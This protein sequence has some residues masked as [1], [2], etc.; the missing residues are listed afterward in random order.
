M[1]V[2]LDEIARISGVSKTTVSYVLSGKQ[3]SMGISE[4]TIR[5][6]RAVADELDYAKAPEAVAL[7]K[8]RQK[9]KRV[10]ILSPWFTNPG[11][12]FVTE[13][14]RLVQDNTWKRKAQVHCQLFE[15]GSLDKTFPDFWKSGPYDT[16]LLMG[17]SPG[18]DVYISGLPAAQRKQIIL[19]NRALPSV[20]S[21]SSDDHT[22]ARDL[23]NAILAANHYRKHVIVHASE[24][25]AIQRR[26]EGIE[27]AFSKRGKPL[28]QTHALRNSTAAEYER[29]LQRYSTDNV[30]YIVLRESTA[31][32]FLCFLRDR[33][34]SIPEQVGVTGYDCSPIS[35]YVSPALTTVDSRIPELCKQA[36]M[37][38][39]ETPMQ[40][41]AIILSPEIVRGASAVLSPSCE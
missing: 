37:A 25:Q 14:S 19:L 9:K 39:L 3:T 41:E 11:S 32:P 29:I 34:L 15:G 20:A 28:P 2:T 4:Q 17:T 16:A 24:S 36:L 26:R 33:G 31:I 5:R 23:A 12:P 22:G 6:V 1:K 40:N 18:D 8:R 10:A 7:A 13:I 30:V 27:E 38:A 21:F 35:S